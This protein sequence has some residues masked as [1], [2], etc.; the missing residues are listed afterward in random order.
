M[1]KGFTTIILIFNIITDLL[2]FLSSQ[3]VLLALR[4]FI[5]EGV[6]IFS[7]YTGMVGSADSISL[8]QQFACH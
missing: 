6:N 2:L 7:I 8:F 4:G 5:V 3:L 1:A